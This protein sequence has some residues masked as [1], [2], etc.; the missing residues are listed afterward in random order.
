M[1][2]LAAPAIVILLVIDMS[3]GLVNR[4]APQLNVF[5]LTLPIKA[6]LATGIILMMLFAPT[7]AAYALSF[8]SADYFALMVLGLVAA[9]T[10]S[11]GSAI[12]GLAMVVLGIAFLRFFTETGL[13][14]SSATLV[15][16]HLVVVFPF[17][18]RLV[19]TAS[20]GIDRLVEN[21]AVS[22]GASRWTTFRRITLPLILPGVISGWMLSFIQSFDE[23]TMSVFISTPQTT[24]LPV[25]LFLYIQDNIDP[26]VASVSA[27]LIALT[28]VVMV[29]LDRIFGMERLLVGPGRS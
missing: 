22:L 11:D 24:T 2:V 15:A 5:A 21:A 6:W 25:R 28:V 20:V 9:S 26:L 16:G 23:V 8:G 7:I 12:K 3:F 29:V 10:I 4:Y 14:V 13:G 17:A 18:L 27:I 19:L 1:L